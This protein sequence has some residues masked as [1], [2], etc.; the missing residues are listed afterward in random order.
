[1]LGGLFF[2][3]MVGLLGIGIALYRRNPQRFLN[4]PSEDA[5]LRLLRWAQATLADLSGRWEVVGV[6]VRAATAQTLNVNGG[7][8]F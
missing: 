6:D 4:G 2:V 3:P 1:M 8:Y 5:P 7:L